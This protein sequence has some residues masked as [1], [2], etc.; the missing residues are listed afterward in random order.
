LIRPIKTKVVLLMNVSYVTTGST[1]ETTELESNQLPEHLELTLERLE[2]TPEHLELMELI[3]EHLEHL[4]P[5][6]EHQVTLVNP[7]HLDNILDNLEH[8]EDTLVNL[9]HRDNTLD[10]LEHTE[11]LHQDNTLELMEHRHLELTELIL[12]LDIL[13][14]KEV[15]LANLVNLDNLDLLMDNL[16]TLNNK[17]DILA[18]LDNLHMEHLELLNN[19][20]LILHLDNKLFN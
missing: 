10:N 16:D 18:N 6:L 3:L 1:P 13:N 12:N 20:D 19:T 17:V 4:E 2:P 7:E 5:T 15:I 8:L 9:E 11:H 14:N